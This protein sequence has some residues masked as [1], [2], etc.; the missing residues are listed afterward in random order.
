MT[1]LLLA[2]F[3]ACGQPVFVVMQPIGK[4]MR[5]FSQESMGKERWEKFLLIIEESKT[6]PTVARLDLPV[7]NQTNLICA[8]ST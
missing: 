8:Q 2:I 5:V 6:D 1:E 4:D 7:E 3:L